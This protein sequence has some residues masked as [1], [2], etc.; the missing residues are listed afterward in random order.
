MKL[1]QPQISPKKESSPAR[2]WRKGVWGNSATPERNQIVD[3]PAVLLVQSRTRKKFSF[4]LEEKIGARKSKIMK[5]TFLRGGEVSERRRAGFLI[6][7]FCSKKFE[8]QSKTPQIDTSRFERRTR[9]DG[10][11]ARDEFF[12]PLRGELAR[13]GNSKGR[14]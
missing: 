4:P 12:S 14:I 7:G 3:S 8:H 10:R 5:K 9:R 1:A 11:T 6:G 2:A 13:R